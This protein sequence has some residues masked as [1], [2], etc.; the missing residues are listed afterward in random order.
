MYLPRH[1]AETDVAEMHALMRAH[2][3]ATLVSD[4]PEAATTSYLS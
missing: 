3:L 2:P 1:F 4:G